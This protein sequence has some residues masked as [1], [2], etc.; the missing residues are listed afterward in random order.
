MAESEM[1]VALR[2][3]CNLRANVCGVKC[4][5]KDLCLVM[6]F[7]FVCFPQESYLSVHENIL[8]MEI[9]TS[10]LVSNLAGEASWRC[11]KLL[12]LSVL[13]DPVFIP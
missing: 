9:D 2:A 5:N 8:W 3:C 11:A 10:S 7:P 4:L 6:L 12:I 1:F 13:V